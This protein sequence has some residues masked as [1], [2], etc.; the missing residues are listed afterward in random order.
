MTPLLHFIIMYNK[1]NSYNLASNKMRVNN[2]NLIKDF[3]RKLQNEGK[4]FISI[5]N[6]KSDISHFLAWAM[7]KLKSFGSY[8]DSASEI[9]PFINKGFFNDYKNYMIENSLKIK[10]INRRLSSLRSFSALLYSTHSVDEDYMVGIQNVGIG[11]L[12]SVQEKSRDI[13]ESFR[14][15]LTEDKKISANTIKNYVADVRSF[16]NWTAVNGTKQ[17]GNLPNE[18]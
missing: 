15:S 4:S 11:I 14:N 9:A 18:G 1:Y 6:Y 5:K 12:S 2:D 3:L 10:T 7:L 13:V 8:A 16:L 17:K